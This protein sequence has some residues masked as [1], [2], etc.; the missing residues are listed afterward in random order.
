MYYYNY[1][2]YN[3]ITEYKF[4]TIILKTFFSKIYYNINFIFI[5]LS[6]LNTILFYLFILCVYFKPILFIYGL[7]AIK[8]KHY[9]RTIVNNRRI[10]QSSNRI[11]SKNKGIFLYIYINI[12]SIKMVSIEI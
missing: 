8:R 4:V 3:Q 12:Y 1:N 7:F 11:L 2:N 10:T 5:I 9:F 6:T